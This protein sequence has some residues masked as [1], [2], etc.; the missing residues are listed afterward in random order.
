MKASSMKAGPKFIYF[1]LDDTLLDHQRAEK[2][3]LKD[4][5][6]HFSLFS[7]VQFGDLMDVYHKINRQQW[8]Y[9]SEGSIDR[10]RLQQNRFELTLN[11]LGVDGSRHQ[12]I[13]KT[14]MRFYRNHWSWVEG[15]FEA[16]EKVRNRYKVGILTNGFSETQKAKFHRFDLYDKAK[17]LVISE[18]VG[19]LKPHPKIFEHATGLTGYKAGEI[20]YVGDSLNSDVK[21]G[22]DFGWMVAWYTNNGTAEDHEK[23]VFTFND[24]KNLTDYL[25]A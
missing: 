6:D 2:N 20:L 19:H 3:A 13:G 23:A 18:E 7:G 12:E 22:A 15:A 5:H 4:I 9:Y 11:E 10:R 21:G 17:H 24:F 16:F 8:I 14:Y 1:D 25:N